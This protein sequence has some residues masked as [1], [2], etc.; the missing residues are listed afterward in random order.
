MMY[1]AW[2]ILG[3]FFPLAP[4]SVAI[5]AQ[6]VAQTT[7]AFLEAI[8]GWATLTAQ[9]HREAAARSFLLK[10]AEK[11]KAKEERAVAVAAAAAKRKEERKE[12]PKRFWGPEFVE[13]YKEFSR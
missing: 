10:E 4:Y 13:C 5:L 12:E 1:F 7:M 8:H 2:H 11:A 9:L 3:S 6:A